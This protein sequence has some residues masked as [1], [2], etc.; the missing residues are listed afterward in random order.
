MVDHAK[1]KSAYQIKE[2]IAFCEGVQGLVD[3]AMAKNYFE[4]ML[5][6][7]R[8]SELLLLAYWGIR[9]EHLRTRLPSQCQVRPLLF[10]SGHGTQGGRGSVSGS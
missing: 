8:H 2:E 4:V 5:Q 10:P 9:P 6:L 7:Q 3:D 1:T